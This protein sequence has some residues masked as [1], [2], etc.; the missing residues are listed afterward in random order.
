MGSVETTLPLSASTI[1]ISFSHPENRRRCWLSKDKPLGPS[2][3]ANRQRDSMHTGGVSDFANR[4]AGIRVDHDHMRRTRDVEV[5]RC[6][7]ERKVI[8][9]AL[10]TQFVCLN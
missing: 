9:A 5:A 2:H 6:R 7:V 3:G 1:A 4:L 8:P 10:T